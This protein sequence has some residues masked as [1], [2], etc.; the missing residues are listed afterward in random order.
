MQVN[1][2]DVK[3]VED[4]KDALKANNTGSHM[5]FIERDKATMMQMVPGN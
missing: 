2:K 3:S 1:R 4:F 5:F